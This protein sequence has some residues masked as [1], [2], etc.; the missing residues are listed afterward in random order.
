MKV[1]PAPYGMEGT[2]WYTNEEIVA[3]KQFIKGDSDNY[4]DGS[5]FYR[6]SIPMN[7]MGAACWA[8]W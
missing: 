6:S 1:N 4:G 5:R 7:H 8:L 2:D 3:N